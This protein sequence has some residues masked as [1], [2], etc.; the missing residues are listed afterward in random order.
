MDMHIGDLHSTI[1]DREL[2]IIQD[3]LEEVLDCEEA[4]F[5]ACD[6]CAELDCLLSFSEASRFHKFQRPEMTEEN[7]IDI[8]Q[9]RFVAFIVI[10]DLQPTYIKTS[11]L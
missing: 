1:V 9:G 4:I 2:E 7:I 8:V 10:L 3:L 6:I 5:T 11:T